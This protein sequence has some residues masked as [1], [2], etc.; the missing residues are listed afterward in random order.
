[1]FPAPRSTNTDARR[2]WC[3]PHAPIQKH[4]AF[5]QEWQKPCQ[6]HPP[7]N[8]CNN[9]ITFL[10]TAKAICR[11]A[12]FARQLPNLPRGR[13][14]KPRVSCRQP[15]RLAS[16]PPPPSPGG[17]VSEKLFAQT[18][19]IGPLHFGT[20]ALSRAGTHGVRPV[21]RTCPACTRTHRPC[22]S[23]CPS[24]RAWAVRRGTHSSAS[25]NAPA[26]GHHVRIA[27]CLPGGDWLP[28]R[29]TATPQRG[30]S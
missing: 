11:S 2:Q 13:D 3:P 27:P 10:L 24:W 5:H 29:S 26:T 14:G 8:I 15:G 9:T 22:R 23:V 18:N 12:E 21:S 20:P 30:T 16:V 25:T 4:N 6:A 19:M 28:R 7:L 1:M 17:C